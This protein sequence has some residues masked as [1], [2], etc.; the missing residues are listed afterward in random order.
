MSIRLSPENRH[1]PIGI[2]DAIHH[3]TAPGPHSSVQQARTTLRALLLSL[4]C[5]H[6]LVP[7]QPH[8]R[9]EPT[10]LGGTDHRARLPLARHP[11]LM[12]NDPRFAQPG[13][14]CVGKFE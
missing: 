13:N 10:L 5:R 12:S 14:L 7:L 9:D 1:L 11:Y 2:E 3:F 4:V 8:A 6:S